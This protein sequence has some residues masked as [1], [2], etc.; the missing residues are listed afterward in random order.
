MALI[1]GISMP[2][3][4]R[5]LSNREHHEKMLREGHFALSESEQRR[6]QLAKAG[7]GEGNDQEPAD[8]QSPSPA[9]SRRA[10]ESSRRPAPTPERRHSLEEMAQRLTGKRRSKDDENAG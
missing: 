6:Q 8:R 9:A 4:G 5:V 3:R 2:G 7:P 10:T 1:A